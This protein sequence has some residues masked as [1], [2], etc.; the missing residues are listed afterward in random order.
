MGTEYYGPVPLSSYAI[1]LSPCSDRIMPPKPSFFSSLGPVSAAIR[2]TIRLKE[3][4]TSSTRW[5]Y[6]Q[7]SGNIM[8]L[9]LCHPMPSSFRPVKIEFQSQNHPFSA[10]LARCPPQSR[11]QLNT[12]SRSHPPHAGI[13]LK[14]WEIVALATDLYPFGPKI[15]VSGYSASVKLG[16]KRNSG[17]DFACRRGL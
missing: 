2:P 11:R 8:G 1:I 9:S 14:V 16:F 17:C 7:M 6:V 10:H 15:A 4:I 5:H 12:R 13:M 3:R